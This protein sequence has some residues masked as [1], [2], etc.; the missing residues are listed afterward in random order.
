[1]KAVFC[2]ST[3]HGVVQAP[4]SKSIAHRMIICAMLSHGESVI[5]SVELSEDIRAT[6]ACISAFGAEYE[7]RDRA[8]FIRGIGG[9]PLEA[10]EEL[11]CGESASS[12]RF[13]TPLCMCAKTG[14]VLT[15]SPRLLARPLGVYEKICKE[16]G[17]HFEKNS[18]S[19]KVCGGLSGSTFRFPGNVSSQFVSGLL[20]ALPMLRSNSE[21][22]L[23]ENVE[24]RPYIDLTLW[25]QRRFG[26]NAQ[27]LS[28]KKLLIPGG[29]TYRSATLENEGD[30]SS[31]AFFFALKALGAEIEVTGLNAS[32]VQGDKICLQHLAAL[33]NGY[34]SIDVSDCPD[35]APLLFVFAA[36]NRG[37]AFTGI[38]RLRDKE[39]DRIA[40]VTQEL[41]KFGCEI[42]VQE[43]ALFIPDA[44]LHA[45]LEALSGHNDHRI[46]MCLSLL[47]IK[48]GGSI[49]GAEAV[50]K[51][52]PSFFE[53]LKRLGVR[54]ELI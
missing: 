1:M 24:S 13:F 45:P 49:T 37:A 6:L 25:V 48:Y 26:V 33:R 12:L 44:S 22:V 21:I 34:C 16:R 3:P 31:A 10:K 29:Q 46:V 52:Y 17:I 38:H 23:T 39:S 43:D 36:L 35:L 27:W 4:P 40:C 28:E 5:R 30:W 9:R 47:C 7:Y 19:V 32:S 54:F 53:D 18:D 51:S 14:G 42:E 50:K 11:R 15:G 20:F 41:R 2:K 8:L